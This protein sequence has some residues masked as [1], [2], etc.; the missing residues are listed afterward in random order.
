V[1]LLI[2]IGI[3]AV[4][5]TAILLL[6]S[7]AFRGTLIGG[8]RTRAVAYARESWEGV[9]S[10]GH[11]AYN[12][13][14]A[15]TYGLS[16]GGGTWAFSGVSD[17]SGLFTREVLVEAVSRDGSGNIVTSGGTNDIHTRKATT[18]ITW[19]FE[20]GTKTLSFVDYFTNW[21]HARFFED[22]TSDFSDG[23]F[24]DT[25]GNTSVDPDGAIALQQS[26]G[27]W[28]CASV[29]GVVDNAGSQ[30]GTDVAISGNYAFLGTLNN[31][32]GGEFVVI[33]K[34][35]PENP[36][37]VA[38]VEIGADVNAIAIV[39][40]YA[41]LAT[42]QNTGELQVINITTPTAPSS[43][44]TLNMTGR[45]DGL[46]IVAS[47]S[48]AYMVRANNAGGSEFFT[49]SITSPASPVVLGS[50]DL[51]ATSR[52]VAM[53]GLYAYAVTDNTTGEFKVVD[54]SV[55]STPTVAATVDLAP[56]TIGQELAIG[57][58]KAYVVTD[59]NSGGDEFFVIDISSPTLPNVQGSV[60]LGNGALTIAL[61]GTNAFVGTATANQR[62]LQI[63]DAGIPTAPTV[64]VSQKISNFSYNG[65][66][67]DGTYLYVASQDNDA[68]FL[69][70]STLATADW[71]CPE[72]K[73]EINLA[74][75]TTA[76]VVYVVGT[77]LYIGTNNNTG[78]HE[79]F[80]YDVSDPY[81]P[82]LIGSLEVG[83]TVNDLVVSGN[84]AYLATTANAAEMRVVSLAVPSAPVSVGTF[85]A[86][87]NTDGQAINIS[88]SLILLTQGATLYHVNVTNPLLPA[89]T[90]SVALGGT[91]YRIEVY[92]ST[93]AY[94][95]TANNSAEVQIINISAAAPTIAAS[96]NI[97]GTSDGRGVW[98]KSTELYVA[99]D[100]GTG[101]G[102]YVYDISTP[103]SPTLLDSLSLGQASYSVVADDNEEFAF[104][105]VNKNG[106]ELK[107]IDT[108]TVT[109]IEISSV[110]NLLNGFINDMYFANDTIYIADQYNSGEV[111]I[112]GKLT[113]GGGGGG[114]TY[115][116]SGT[117]VSSVL[118]ALAMGNWNTIEWSE[119]QNACV[120]GTVALQ[121]RSAVT[122]GALATALWQ[123]PDGEDLDETDYFTDE[124]GE[125]IHFDHNGD[126]YLQYRVTLTSDGSCTPHFTDITIT[127][128]PY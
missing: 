34:T 86:A 97:S 80:L 42:S 96:I 72:Q 3:F 43:V 14:R 28:A 126:Q 79:F 122:T 74:G 12:R 63:V 121:V 113:G 5:G 114:G 107:V 40:Q 32:A 112:I 17:T 16:D 25:S 23:T 44:A 48:R 82:T 71:S 65:L 2:S 45:E 116:T 8:Q 89:S 125:L 123:G 115:S 62:T 84:Y 38:S 39:G 128:T 50:V 35:D 9:K 51:A 54:I 60:D 53:S 94:V 46:D 77:T 95:A 1:E 13:L 120:S 36:V 37:T 111:T 110:I 124:I 15:G 117:Y 91:G 75:N 10:I 100:S 27:I 18:N 81:T 59:N 41:Y 73:S 109:A 119:N 22:T 87:G 57:G 68:E 24:D 55:D 58:S 20:G 92:S 85:N 88:G 31:A 56:A 21:D 29:E 83:D 78:G 4:A 30:P 101:D 66:Y 99:V 64:A 90:G 52:G 6:V 67:W 33:D 61:D 108:N 69:I 98:I 127:Y 103:T 93:Y 26:A 70:M 11:H 104:S 105:S 19:T 106:Q 118:D 49:I 76:N 7:S 47:G 102:L